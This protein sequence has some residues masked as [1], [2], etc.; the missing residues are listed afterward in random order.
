MTI[1]DR[2]DYQGAKCIS[3]V[4]CGDCIVLFLPNCVVEIDAHGLGDRFVCDAIRSPENHSLT[5]VLAADRLFGRW[6]LSININVGHSS[7]A[8]AM[9]PNNDSLESNPVC[10]KLS[11]Q[12]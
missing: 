7:L 10:D 6:S 8:N 9:V 1:C 4:R 3:E 12:A 2:V 5:E 11:W